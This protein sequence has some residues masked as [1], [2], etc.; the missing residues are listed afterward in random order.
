MSAEHVWAC[1]KCGARVVAPRGTIVETFR[2][3]AEQCPALPR[4]R[5]PAPRRQERP[6]PPRPSGAAARRP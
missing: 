3:H 6:E 2:A 5:R 1:G 4:R